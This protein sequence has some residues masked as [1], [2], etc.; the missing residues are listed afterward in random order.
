MHPMHHTRFNSL[1]LRQRVQR[2]RSGFTLIELV[3][4]MSIVVMLIGM[5]V[6]AVGRTSIE[7]KF[8]EPAAKLKEFARRARNAAVLEQRPYQVEITP[9]SL[10][11]TP[12]RFVGPDSGPGAAPSSSQGNFERFDI[13]AD[14]EFAVRRWNSKNFQPEG[15]SFVWKFQHSGLSE[16][17]TVRV[18]GAEG[19]IEMTF[20]T[21]DAH[22]ESQESQ[23]SE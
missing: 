4:A 13:D 15:S 2:R 16:P 22:V 10:V 1:T 21:L 20:N 19:W 17:I 18:E 9:R 3:L 23:I 11:L 14:V 8:Q 7:K 5:T 12:Q 6:M